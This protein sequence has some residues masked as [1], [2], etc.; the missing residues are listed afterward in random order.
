MT[1]LFLT[2]MYS[3]VYIVPTSYYEA[4]Y[5]QAIKSPQRIITAIVTGYSSTRSQTDS[6]PEIMAS[7]KRVYEG[8]IA[9]NC[10]PFG[11]KVLIAEKEYTVEDRMNR[12][13]GCGYYD[14]W[15]KDRKSAMNF[16][17]QQL[18]VIIK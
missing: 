10:L 13:Y 11:T 12:R 5:V 3:M 6:S 7:N 16:G 15:H 9:N 1:F 14:I 2:A 8:A 17:R 4:P 18:A